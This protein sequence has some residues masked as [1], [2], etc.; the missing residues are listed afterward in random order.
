MKYAHHIAASIV[1][2]LHSR[3]SA[4]RK[5]HKV[6]K[7]MNVFYESSIENNTLEPIRIIGFKRKKLH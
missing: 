5:V 7:Y 1:F 4:Q 2:I 6:F 3:V